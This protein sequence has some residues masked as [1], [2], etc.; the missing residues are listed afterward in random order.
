MNPLLQDYANILL[1]WNKTHNLSGARNLSELEP[2]IL[3]ALKPLEFIKDFKTCLDIGSGA[4][5]PAIP[6]ALERPNTQF[7]LL[8]PRVKRVAFL[9]YLKSVLPLK[10][11]EIIKK[12]LEDYKNPLKVDLITSRA[13]ASSSFL[14]EKSQHLLENKGYFLFYK[15]EQLKDE[16]AY[17][18]TECFIYEKRI[19][20]YK[21]KE[22][23]C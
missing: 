10:N 22:S 15:G 23:L 20:F 7:I 8:E 5:L 4:G 17:K 21:S 2:Q 9:N 6:L 3:D 14:I 1:E 12:R 19:Y 18:D 13:V 11:I 16:I